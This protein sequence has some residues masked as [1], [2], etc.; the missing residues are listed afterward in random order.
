MTPPCLLVHCEEILE[1]GGGLVA[2]CH[3]RMELRGWKCDDKGRSSKLMIV[4]G[5]QTNAV[6]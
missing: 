2:Q 4:G 6:V 3:H 1:E 5:V